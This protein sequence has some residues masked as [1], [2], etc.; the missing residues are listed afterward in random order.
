MPL[1]KPTRAL[2]IDFSHPLARGLTGCWLM[3]EATGEIVADCGSRCNNGSF[4]YSTTT[5]VWKP[6]KFGSA[7]EFG[8]ERCIYCGTGKF[9]WDST[10]EISIIAFVN[11]S[12]SQTNTLFARSGFVRPCKL[13]A[14]TSGRFKWWVYTD[15]TNCIINST[16]SHATDGSEYVHVAGTW[17]AGDGKL[18][19]NGLQEASESSSSG[20]L[21]FYNDS[22][23]VG[24]GG[25]YEGSNYYYCLN[26]KIEYVFIYNRALSAEEIR[27]LYRLPFAMFARPISP[28]LIPVTS[29]TVSLAGSVSATSAGSAALTLTGNLPKVELNWLKDALFNG[30]TSN[31]FKLGTILSLGWFWSRIVGCSVLYRGPGFEQIDFD[32]VLTAAEI[33]ANQI[34]PPDYLP[35]ES[36]LTYFYVVRRYNHSGYQEHT[37]AAV[38]KVSL[39]PEGQL[40]KPQPN[41]IYTAW[42]E[43]VDA[44]KV[45]LT[46]FYCPLE[47]SSQPECFNIYYDNRAGQIDYENPLAVI[48]YQGQKFY[49][50]ESS[51]LETGRY[52]FTIRAE[53]IDG[54]ENSSSAYLAIELDDKDPD[55]IN[56]LQA[57][58]S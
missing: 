23:S 52:L 39:D 35:H 57:E 12:A 29:A 28:A 15:G 5:P 22:Q 33:N 11:Q 9:G 4:H 26:G 32:T 30:M 8:S 16:S 31:S 7:L 56:I 6:G 42:V 18:Y 27:W 20:S 13:S 45:R 25:T 38:A 34:S 47:Q 40:H 2:Q 55:A 48:S 44:N 21:S 3:N 50:F 51:S 1:L 46:W 54:N 36:N 37:L 53:D 19:V 14:L 58:P 49:C 43:R 41:K 24:I 10:N 17:R